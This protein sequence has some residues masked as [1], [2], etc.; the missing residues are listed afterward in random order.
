[1][2]R[3]GALLLPLVLLASPLPATPRR[4]NW[5]ATETVDLDGD[6][7]PEKIRGA[8]S[9]LFINGVVAL[10]DIN[11]HEEAVRPWFEIVAVD[12]DGR[13]RQIALY[14]P[15][16]E[17]ECTFQ[18]VDLRAGKARSLLRVAVDPC[19][20]GTIAIDNHRLRVRTVQRPTPASPSECRTIDTVYRVVDGVLQRV[21]RAISKTHP[22]PPG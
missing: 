21:S 5:G 10:R 6:G 4:T 14:E 2:N 19:T 20:T 13:H 11:D 15:G 8:D 12:R 1:M 17:D 7:T 22:C 3:F 16:I 18:L 9:Q